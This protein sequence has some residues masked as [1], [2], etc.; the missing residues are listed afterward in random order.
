MAARKAQVPVWTA[1]DLGA[2]P[3]GIGLE[4]SPTKVVKIFTPPPRQG[5]EVFTGEP[6][7]VVAKLVEKLRPIIVGG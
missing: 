7:E 4:G 3:A 2:D 5:G 6:G 1:A